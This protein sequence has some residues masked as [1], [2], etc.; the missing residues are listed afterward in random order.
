MIVAAALCPA[1]PLLIPALTGAADVLPELRAA[2]LEA[3]AELIAAGPEVIAVVGPADITRTWEPASRLDLAAFAPARGRGQ[4]TGLLPVP[5]QGAPPA[6]DD[7]A[8]GLPASLG[9]GA[10]LLDQAGYS[11]ER[12]LQAVAHDE[13]SQRC[14]SLGASLA[15]P[16]EAGTAEAGGT[17]RAGGTGQRTALLVMAD[18]SA[19]RGPRAPGHFDPRSA[20]FDAEVERAVREADLGALLA[21][22]AGVARELMAAGRPAWQVMSGALNGSKVATRLRYSDDPFGV[23]YLVASLRVA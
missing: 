16:R 2:C 23:A 17:G 6:T 14:A 1:P 9:V 20:E 10:C 21:I 5:Q 11:G 18:G 13:P 4:G 15:G 7:G 3:V 12:L 19:C 8:A 22:D